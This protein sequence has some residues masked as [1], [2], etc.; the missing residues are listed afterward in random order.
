MVARHGGAQRP[1][2]LTATRTPAA[3]ARASTAGSR[4]R[5]LGR[6]RERLLGEHVLAGLDRRLDPV[7]PALGAGGEVDVA[8]L[9][10]GQQ[11]LGAGVDAAD[12]REP[13]ADRRGGRRVAAPDAG[14]ADAVLLVGRQVGG[15]RDGAA[16]EDRDAASGLGEARRGVG[17]GALTRAPAPPGSAAPPAGSSGSP[18][19]EP[20]EDRG[21]VGGVDHVGDQGARVDPAGA[22]PGP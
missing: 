19:V 6:Q 8:H 15:L 18:R 12:E 22:R 1:L 17:A 7:E 13:L 3:S 11:L 10:V 4:A 14:H 16:A 20:L 21:H 9:G 2:W 5:S